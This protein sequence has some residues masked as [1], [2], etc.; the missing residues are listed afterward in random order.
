[1]N[2][3]RRAGRSVRARLEQQG[4]ALRSKL[5]VDLLREDGVDGGLNLTGRHCWIEHQHVWAKAR[6]PDMRCF[7]SLD[8]GAESAR[9]QDYRHQDADCPT[10]TP[11]HL[12]HLPALSPIQCSRKSLSRFEGPETMQGRFDE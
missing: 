5:V 12:A 7:I 10:N 6:L 2:V 1:M 8:C 3:Q 11:P 9:R 4:E